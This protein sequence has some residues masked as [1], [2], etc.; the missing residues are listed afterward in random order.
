M[1]NEN[2]YT[3]KYLSGLCHRNTSQRL[4][5]S[6][7]KEWLVIKGAAENNLKGLDVRIPIGLMTCVTGVSG[8]GKK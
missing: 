8:S 2:S 7:D 6:H 4:E 3:G 1:E 5:P